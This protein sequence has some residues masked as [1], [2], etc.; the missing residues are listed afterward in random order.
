[1]PCRGPQPR[2]L[3]HATRIPRGP[4]RQRP[5]GRQMQRDEMRPARNTPPTQRAPA[6]G[7]PARVGGAAARAA[8]IGYS[9]VGCAVWSALGPLACT[10]GAAAGRPGLS[11]TRPGASRGRCAVLVQRGRRRA[12]PRPAPP[13]ARSLSLSARNAAHSSCRLILPAGCCRCASCSWLRLAACRPA[14][15][16][17]QRPRGAAPPAGPGPRRRRLA[18]ASRRLASRSA[19]GPASDQLRPQ[20]RAPAP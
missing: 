6:G 1:M 18:L 4:E 11:H 8:G 3:A 13:P 17:S 15:A 10:A 16:A 9:T 12:G 20:S 19:R 14:A 7:P 5:R 2:D